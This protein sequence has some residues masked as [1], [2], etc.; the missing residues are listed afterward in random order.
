VVGDGAER[1][2]GIADEAGPVVVVVR[3]SDEAEAIRLANDTDYG[4]AAPN[5][6]AMYSREGS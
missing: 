2:A 3:A 4:L 5:A 6:G 1:A